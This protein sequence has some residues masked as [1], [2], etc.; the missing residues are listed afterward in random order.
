MTARRANRVGPGNA[1]VL[2]G[3][4]SS[5]GLTSLRA[6][7]PAVPGV[8]PEASF[9]P[10][11]DAFPVGGFYSGTLGKDVKGGAGG[12]ELLPSPAKAQSTSLRRP[13]RSISQC[14][15]PSSR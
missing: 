4:G 8:R 13:G 2:V 7:T 5:A 1:E 14:G 15:M 12:D 3:S 6:R 11:L 10:V 9:G